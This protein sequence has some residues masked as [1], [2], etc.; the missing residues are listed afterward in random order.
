MAEDY[1]VYNGDVGCIMNRR[2]LEY[3]GGDAQEETRR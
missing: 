2:G 1:N 3:N